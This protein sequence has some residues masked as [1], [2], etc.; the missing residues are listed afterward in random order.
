M[1][2]VAPNIL[3]GT[4]IYVEQLNTYVEIQYLN[5][6]KE[7]EREKESSKKKVRIS[8]L[9][10]HARSMKNRH[11]VFFVA[12]IDSSTDVRSHRRFLVSLRNDYSQ[13]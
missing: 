6:A 5:V 2:A 7:T 3:H 13:W 9:C 12:L 4:K 1:S 8:L 11:G 10:V